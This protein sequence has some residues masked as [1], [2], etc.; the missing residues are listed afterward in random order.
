M[1]GRRPAQCIL[2]GIVVSVLIAVPT[3]ML[4]G[5]EVH[6]LAGERS[7]LLLN[8]G[9]GPVGTGLAEGLTAWSG[10]PDAV[11]WNPAAAKFYSTDGNSA[12]SL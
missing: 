11:W 10:S 6:P 8:L 1:T 9:F 12:L 5:Q 3:D 4:S 2:A 7:V